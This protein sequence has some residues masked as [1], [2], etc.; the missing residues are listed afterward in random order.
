[1]RPKDVTLAPLFRIHFQRY[2][3][4]WQLTDLAHWKEKQRQIAQAEKMERELDARTADRVRIG[5]QQ[6]EIDHNLRSEH[7]RSGGGSQDKRWRVARDGGWFSYELKLPPAG[8]KAAVRVLYWGRDHDREFEIQLDG[9]VIATQK[10]QGGKD[11]YFG[12]EYPIP[13]ALAEGRDKVTVR[14]QAKPGNTA[15]GVFDVR[16]VTVK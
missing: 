2:A 14:F 7:S 4:Y 8:T 11:D 10:L 1:V 9:T 3:I 6:P 13:E 12:V 5:E 15:G 16:I